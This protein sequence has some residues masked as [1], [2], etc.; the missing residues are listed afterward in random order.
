M[1]DIQE[2]NKPS[3]AQISENETDLMNILSALNETQQRG[4]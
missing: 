4:R 3:V 2:M 1:E